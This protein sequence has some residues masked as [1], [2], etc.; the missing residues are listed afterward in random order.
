M[1]ARFGETSERRWVRWAT[2][3]FGSPHKRTPWLSREALSC[4]CS[5]LTADPQPPARHASLRVPWSDPFWWAR[6]ELNLRPL[7][8]QRSPRDRGDLRW[9]GGVAGDLGR[10]WAGVDRCCPLR[11]GR[12]WPGCGPDVAPAV[13]LS[14]PILT[15]RAAAV[16]VH[17]KQQPQ[18][19]CVQLIHQARV[20]GIHHPGPT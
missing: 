18:G 17:G 3:R 9:V 6:E 4:R 14:D 10:W 19:L 16:G 5:C 20:H 2:H 13:G 12:S 11:S 1:A 7:P 8:C 15:I